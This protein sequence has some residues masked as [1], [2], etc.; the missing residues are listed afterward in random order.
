MLEDFASHGRC[1]SFA[2]GAGDGDDLP[3]QE[4]CGQLHFTDYVN[5]L[6]AR[7]YKR[8]HI[9]RHAGADHDQVLSAEG[10]LTVASGL[11]RNATVDQLGNPLTN[12]GLGLAVRPPD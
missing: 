10:A 7:L 3:L 9:I 1:R 2:V 4:A 12:L 11:D 5:A 8:A 6:V